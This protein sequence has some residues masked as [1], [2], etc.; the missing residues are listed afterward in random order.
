VRFVTKLPANSEKPAL[1]VDVD[2]VVSLFGFASNARPD[3]TWLTVD[4]IVHSFRPQPVSTSSSSPST[5]T[6]SGALAGRE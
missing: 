2:R 1:L 4:G 3:G 6:W 5:S